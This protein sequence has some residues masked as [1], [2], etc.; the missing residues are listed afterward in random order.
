[1]R[2][3]TFVLVAVA[4]AATAG[5]V[6]A[7]EGAVLGV[8]RSRQ[9]EA[10]VPTAWSEVYGREIDLW[11]REAG[12]A[13]LS[14]HVVGDVELSEG[15][16]TFDA[17]VVAFP[18]F[19]DPRSVPRFQALVEQARRVLLVGGAFRSSS[20]VERLRVACGAQAFE[21]L[22]STTARLAVLKGRSFLAAEVA[23][24]ALLEVR[25]GLPAFVTSS[26]HALAWY[27][28]ADLEPFEAGRGVEGSAAVVG[29][30]CG[31]AEVV[32]SGFP[33]SALARDGARAAQADAVVANLVS[34]L[35]GQPWLGRAPWRD[36][37]SL[38]I[39]L[40][41]DVGA[42]LATASELVP[43]LDAARV[44][45]SFRVDPRVGAGPELLASLARVGEVEGPMPAEAA[46]ALRPLRGDRD[47]CDL[48][49][50]TGG[51]PATAVVPR[52][53]DDVALTERLGGLYVLGLHPACLLQQERLS[54]ITLFLATTKQFPAW[55]ATRGEVGAW[56]RARAAVVVTRA[57]GGFR[58][59]NTGPIALA[60]FP[61][62]SYR[63][64]ADD[65]AQ[66]GR[67]GLFLPRDDGGTTFVLDLNAGDE[68]FLPVSGR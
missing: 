59:T 50:A 52:L 67:R 26:P 14:F 29:F 24:G 38:A 17:V 27:A 7:D 35:S 37:R 36:D 1:M 15:H 33:L 25:A 51:G 40:A 10:H 30:T 20:A 12:R 2:A 16:S 55:F 54:A 5:P 8:V 56:Q 48:L 65:L 46:P 53:V 11:V 64:G 68:V 13:G 9:A 21:L 57:A 45:G 6:R 49:T 18:D 28:G 47:D 61:L 58:V 39:V 66:L 62:V 34:W 3:S 42:P 43:V 60:S 22:P 31:G 4:L 41:V 23:P 19:D 63:F 44:R 32:W